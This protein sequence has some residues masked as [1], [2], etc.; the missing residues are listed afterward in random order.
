MN[1]KAAI[2]F[3]ILSPGLFLIVHPALGQQQGY[4]ST[5]GTATLWF[6]S[7]NTGFVEFLN[8]ANASGPMILTDGQHH[9]FP[10][11]RAYIIIFTPYDSNVQ[12]EHWVIDAAGNTTLLDPSSYM[13]NM[14]LR[15]DT[16]L[17]AETNVPVP[18]IPT[19][20]FSTPLAV[21]FA[22]VAVLLA[23]RRHR[24]CHNA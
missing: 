23:L 7:G 16:I 8:Y 15:G 1:L 9:A 13:T 21:L 17:I 12:F 6:F 4:D 10:A 19:P 2:I 22:A 20:E 3:A 18:S 5:G 11:N 24:P 14:T